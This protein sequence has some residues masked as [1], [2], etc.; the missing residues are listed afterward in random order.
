VLSEEVPHTATAIVV[1]D[2]R[3]GREVGGGIIRAQRSV[4]VGEVLGRRKRN[5]Q[6]GS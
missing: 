2:G 6:D 5:G 4:E 1:A 3:Q